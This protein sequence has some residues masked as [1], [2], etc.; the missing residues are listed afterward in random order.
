MSRS[1]SP[2]VILAG[3]AAI[4]LSVGCSDSESS[5][6]PVVTQDASADGH[7]AGADAPATDGLLDGPGDAVADAVMDASPQEGGTDS[8]ADAAPACKRSVVAC[9]PPAGAFF[10]DGFNDQNAVQ[11]AWGKDNYT[12]EEGEGGTGT[13]LAI[14]IPSSSP[15]TSK[16][17]THV[18]PA[19][20]LK[21]TR[22]YLSVKVKAQ[23]VSAKP[24]SWNGIKVMLV[25][26]HSDGSKSYPQIG[27]D[28][29]T[30]DWTTKSTVV[31]VAHD[32]VAAHLV[33]GLEQV[34]GKVWFDDLSLQI[35]ACPPT[36]DIDPA[37]PIEKGH[38]PVPSLRG[39]MISPWPDEATRQAA[40]STL[41]TWGANNVRWQLSP[42]D[43]SD[44]S[45]LE[46]P[47]FEQ[48]LETGLSRLDA[49][50]P[51]LKQAGIHVILDLHNLS[52]NWDASE[53][54]Q[55]RFVETW[56]A[57][58]SRYKNEPAIWA[59][60]LANEPSERQLKPGLLVWEQLAEKTGKAIRAIDATR[61]IIVE[62]SPGGGPS[63]FR[64]LYP[65]DVPD[66]VYSVHMYEP[67]AFTHQEV[68]AEYTQTTTYPGTISGKVWNKDA[69]VAA[70]APVLDFQ[71]RTRTQIYVG[72][73]SAVR[74]A[75]GAATY[76]TDV[77][78]IFEG[79]DWDWSY[80]AFREWSGWSVECPSDKSE[81]TGYV[82]T[83]R[84]QA[85]R[86]MLQKN[87]SP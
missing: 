12:V 22:V 33:I 57:M 31:E 84:Q 13:S 7:D 44:K 8:S 53:A 6:T 11:S 24:A 9:T 75:P 2:Y 73:F 48:D 17:V 1:E 38:E 23:D 41:Q 47:N 78:D 81:C 21:G 68:L 74:W 18:V 3:A 72:E 61:T 59:Y 42:A 29:G 82:M 77:M 51:L 5:N 79:Y 76:L 43:F 37:C 10:E 65:I 52:L 80:H 35:M 46:G 36:V 54:N 14:A 60:D 15:G 39:V 85:L 20:Q 69:L 62:P 40:V 30:F 4:A 63:A 86:A 26:E 45:G 66:V 49:A 55:T 50:L 71:Q 58:A 70:L 87:L 64:N 19:D 32:L 56:K 67:G 83:D 16:S 28:V 27:L 34:T 25:L